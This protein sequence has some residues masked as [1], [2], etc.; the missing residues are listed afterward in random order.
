M[1]IN[2]H[3]NG[4]LCYAVIDGMY[5]QDEML[6]VQKE[7]EFLELNKQDPTQTKSAMANNEPLKHGDGIFLDKVYNERSFS[8]LLQLNRRLFDE[9]VV[10][11][12]R[13]FNCFYDHIRT[14]NNDN[15]LINFYGNKNFYKPHRDLS[16]ITAL[17]FFKIGSFEGGAFEFPEH[18]VEIEPV[19]GRVV[20]FP[21]CVV[22]AARP[23]VAD[24]GSY[25]VTMAQFLNY[26]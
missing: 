1:N 5:S 7:I 21:G 16:V 13:K 8:P 3:N 2:A 22:H 20:I 14:C 17:T 24:E 15:T 12:L 6:I 25:R 18:E 23:V 10:N 4:P 19:C 9:Q 26:V 11:H